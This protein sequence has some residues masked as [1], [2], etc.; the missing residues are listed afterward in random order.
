M[1]RLLGTIKNLMVQQSFFILSLCLLHTRALMDCHCS[2]TS[3]KLSDDRLGVMHM[4]VGV[5]KYK[6]VGV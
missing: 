2:V 4:L 1:D 6:L 3:A 5:S